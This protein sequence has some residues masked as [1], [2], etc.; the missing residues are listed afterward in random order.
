MNAQV[1]AKLWGESPV[2]VRVLRL[3]RLTWVGVSVTDAAWLLGLSPEE[4]SAAV[5]SL[6][7]QGLVVEVG[8]VWRAIR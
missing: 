5:R 7:G 6:A 8:G 3:L 4:V 2:D 1:Q